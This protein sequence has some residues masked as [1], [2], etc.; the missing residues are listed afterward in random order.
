MG[1][2]DKCSACDIADQN[3]RLLA[4]KGADRQCGTCRYFAE[5]GQCRRHA[6]SVDVVSTYAPVWPM[7]T[8]FAWCGDWTDIEETKACGTTDRT[9]EAGHRGY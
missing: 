7:V 4:A 1:K 6:P 8:A 3:A 9:E 5:I 2:E